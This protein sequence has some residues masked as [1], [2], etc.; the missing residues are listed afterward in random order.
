M[1]IMKLP[2][3]VATSEGQVWFIGKRASSTRVLGV[4]GAGL[5]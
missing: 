2:G 4:T 5:A 3:V 1:P